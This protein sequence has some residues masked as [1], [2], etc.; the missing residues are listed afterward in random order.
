MIQPSITEVT[1]GF[2]AYLKD[3]G[4]YQDLEQAADILQKEAHR[5][6]DISVISALELSHQEQKDLEQALVERFGEHKLVFTVDE[7]LLSGL[8][9][10]FQDQFIDLTGTGR[11]SHLANLVKP[12]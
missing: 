3:Q 8:A 6:H 10:K 5:N 12:Q 9:I 4:L 11:L 1:H 2:I 7:A